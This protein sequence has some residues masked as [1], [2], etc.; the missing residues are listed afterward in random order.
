MDRCGS[1]CV[2]A[3]RTS[4]EPGKAHLSTTCV[5]VRAC[6]CVR[7]R[8]CVTVHSG[9]ALCFRILRQACVC[10]SISTRTDLPLVRL[11]TF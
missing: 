7:A 1:V 4:V 8:S 6:A 5:A 2:C 11:R 10:L 3:P 9:D